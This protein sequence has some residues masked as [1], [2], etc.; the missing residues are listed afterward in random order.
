MDIRRKTVDEQRLFSILIDSFCDRGNA[1]SQD[2]KKRIINSVI[3]LAVILAAAFLIGH[4]LRQNNSQQAA[5]DSQPAQSQED[6]SGSDIITADGTSLEEADDNDKEA[7]YTFRNSYLRDEHF[8]KHG[9]EFDYASA[10]EYEAGASAV[11][12]NPAALHKKE[13]DDNDDI[14]YLK[15]TNE[16]VIVST[17]GYIRTYFRPRSGIKYYNKQ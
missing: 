8:E 2:T 14:Y 17:D 4:F 9:D 6:S 13:A 11:V 15:K 5:P 3:R 7:I 1:M 16:F 10:E 12:N